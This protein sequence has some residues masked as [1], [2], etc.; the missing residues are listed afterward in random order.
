MKRQLILLIVFLIPFFGKAQEATKSTEQFLSEI[1]KKIPQLLND[2]NVPGAA[3]AIIENG[4]V[5]LQKGYGYSDMEKGTKVDTKTGFNIGSIS[6]TVAAWGVMKLVQEGKIDLDAPA[7]KYLTRWHLPKS[8]FNSEGVTVRRMLSHTAGLSLHGYPGW[9]PDDQLPTVEESLNGKN[10]GPGRVE[11]IME[12]GTKW[13]Y[14]GGGFTILQLI[15]EEVTGQRFEDFMQTEI[16]N[17]LGMSNSSYQISEK[18]MSTSSL[19]YNA[20]GEQ[21]DFEL[22]TA[23]A[24]AG[25]HT[26][27][28]DFIL[29][30]KAGLYKN[31]NPEK[32]N[33]VLKAGTIQQMMEPAEASN[34]YYG[35]GYQ[36]MPI[37]ETSVVLR[38]HGGANTGWHAYFQ[39][40]PMTGNGF[41]MFTNGGAGYNIYNQIFCNWINWKTGQSLGR[42]CQAKPSVANKIKRIIDE[43]GIGDVAAAYQD[44]KKNQAEKFNFSESQLNEL[45]YHYLGKDEVENA[46]A[47]FKLNI[48]AFPNASNVYDSYGEA[49]LIKGEKE[50]AIE[51]YKKSIKL[52]PGNDHGINVLKELGVNTDE[53]IFKVPVEDLKLLEGVYQVVNLPA[54]MEEWLI[55]FELENEVLFGNDRGYRYR[56]LPVRKNEFINPDDGEILVFDTEN[57]DRI[58]LELFGEYKFR[59]ISSSKK[60]DISFLEI[61]NSWRKEIFPFPL[62]FAPDIK[63]EGLEEAR[64]LPGW[65]EMESDEFWSYAFVWSINLSEELTADFLQEN[66]KK[67]FDGLMK[68]VNK[69]KGKQL[70]HT[71]AE[72]HK[73]EAVNGRPYFAGTVQVYDAFKTKKTLALN[74]IVE[75]KHC[76]QK[77]KSV[78]LFRFSPKGF[79]DDVWFKLNEVKLRADACSF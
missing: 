53:L 66:L 55:E 39:A 31:K 34:G 69:D 1:D 22:F 18:I 29:F 61:D 8:E 51:N 48:N 4:E 58:S 41:I 67:Y 62:S 68:A 35:L 28:E 64:F 52:N 21:I 38:G 76:E 71:S 6:K 46:L 49:L 42:R 9:S 25:L 27:I 26:T 75:Q 15:V 23:Q 65:G 78:M 74:V 19:E 17:P 37:R 54:D 20:F 73:K 50:K 70:P 30:A 24:A 79:D 47:I 63:Y 44:L 7:E 45:G 16:L 72:F 33:P 3:L 57:K 5:V 59:K 10:N 56:V 2:F 77:N 60:E 12:P 40:D 32:N 11:I 43:K 13:K 14:S 36:V